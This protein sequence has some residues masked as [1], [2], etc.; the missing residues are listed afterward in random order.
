MIP[1]VVRD[2]GIDGLLRG[3]VSTV[4]QEV[5]TMIAD[6]ARNLLLTNIQEDPPIIEGIDLVARNI[7][8]GGD[9]RI[10]TMNAACR[11]LGLPRRRSFSEISS[12]PEVV[13][14]IES[15]R[16]NLSADQVDGF[17]GALAEDRV[18]GSS[19]GELLRAS[20]ANDFTRLRDGDLFFYLSDGLFSDELRALLRVERLSITTYRRCVKS[21]LTL[22]VSLRLSFQ[23]TSSSR[24]KSNS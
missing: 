16:G 14:A 10:P 13:E 17:V 19:F 1:E 11:A 24:T 21:S 2:N 18:E 4:A 20:W 5:D 6:S 3:M 9:H 8:R 15:L 7:Q 23:A 22:Q 12:D